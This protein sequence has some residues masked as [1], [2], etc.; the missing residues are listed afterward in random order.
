VKPAPFAY[1]RPT[2]VDEALGLLAEHG[3]EAKPLAGG[4]S[5]VPMLA[6]RLARFEHLVDLNHV[7]G[8]A[9]LSRANGDLV[10]GAMT[11]Q[12]VLERDQQVAGA[13]PLLARATP[14]IGHFQ[15]RN[16]G[17][18]GGSL[19]HADPA[20]EYPAV[21]VALD[22]TFEVAGPRGSRTV[23]A[24]T[25]FEGTWRTCLQAD[26]LLRAVRFPVATGHS[27]FAIREIAR[28]EGDFALA[29]AAAAV[30]LNADGT[31]ARLGLGLFGV[32]PT[33]IRAQPAEAAAA[34]QPAAALLGDAPALEEL[35]HLAADPLEPPDDVHA[36][37]SYRRRVAAHLVTRA[38][39]SALEDATHG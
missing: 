29:G 30:T 21:A 1:H 9:G 39:R 20:S 15:I 25:F 38:V 28:R 32:G 6:L 8:L 16:R 22:A 31:I 27:G 13:V 10:V 19:A 17:T 23:D 35:G 5:L 12:A 3:D 4:Q 33:P 14:L 18:A 24:A 11:R 7:A 26:E 37:G 36:S 34:G 2:T